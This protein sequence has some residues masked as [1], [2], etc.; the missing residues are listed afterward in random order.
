MSA[1]LQPDED[2]LKDKETNG[3]SFISCDVPSGIDMSET[4][5]SDAREID[6]D[7]HIISENVPMKKSET[8]TQS[9]PM[10]Y[11]RPPLHRSPSSI[12]DCTADE[13]RD[14]VSKNLDTSACR[15][16]LH[17]YRHDNCSSSPDSK[18]VAVIIQEDEDLISCESHLSEKSESE[19]SSVLSVLSNLSL[20]R[21]S[22]GATKKLKAMKQNG[23]ENK[24]THLSQKEF[25]AHLRES[26]SLQPQPDHQLSTSSSPFQS[27]LMS[28][29]S[30]STPINGCESVMTSTEVKR[31][32][33]GATCQAGP[34]PD[35]WTDL[36]PEK[37]T[38]ETHMDQKI[39]EAKRDWMEVLNNV[40]HEGVEINRE[41]QQSAFAAD[42][43]ELIP[44]SNLQLSE[45]HPTKQIMP[46]IEME[47][48]TSTSHLQHHPSSIILTDAG[49]G[50]SAAADTDAPGH[51]VQRKEEETHPT[52]RRQRDLFDD[53]SFH[54]RSIQFK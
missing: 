6:P 17:D 39:S 9:D 28:A 13:A 36:T 31:M 50:A 53:I 25:L 19:N 35:K 52:R 24:R 2:E 51:A 10:T 18:K 33:Q 40:K 41:K 38:K 34:T 32:A 44:D 15:I 45:K 20:R 26:M 30:P 27:L 23:N 12:L 4:K 5:R 11:A 37:W 47:P 14:R 42:K 21:K 48:A 43:L 29:P 7:I 49:D 16:F 1:A 8:M 54:R 46:E 3:F 22:P